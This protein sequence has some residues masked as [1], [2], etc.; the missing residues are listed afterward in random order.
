[1][2]YLGEIELAVEFS[3]LESVEKVEITRAT[4]E[5]SRVDI[6]KELIAAVR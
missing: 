5:I 2:I 4:F 1:M 3:T 6:V